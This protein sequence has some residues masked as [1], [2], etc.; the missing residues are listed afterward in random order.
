[1]EKISEIGLEKALQSSRRTLIELSAGANV[2]CVP[3][4]ALVLPSDDFSKIRHPRDLKK[5]TTTC[6]CCSETFNQK[7]EIFF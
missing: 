2:R 4:G 6:F 5:T 7:D 1:M 3:L